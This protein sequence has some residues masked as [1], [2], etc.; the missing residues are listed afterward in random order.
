MDTMGWGWGWDGVTHQSP[1]FT[2]AMPSAPAGASSAD[3]KSILL[4]LTPLDPSPLDPI[5][6]DPAPPDPALLAPASGGGSRLSLRD[7]STIPCFLLWQSTGGLS[8][9]SLTISD[10]IAAAVDPIPPL[11]AIPSASQEG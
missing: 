6:P 8:Y 1:T 3:R 2:T 5:P 9:A 10:A 4:D 7:M 11:D